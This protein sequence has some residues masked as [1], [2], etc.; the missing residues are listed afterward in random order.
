MAHDFLNTFIPML[1]FLRSAGLPAASRLQSAMGA[2]LSQGRIFGQHHPESAVSIAAAIGD[3]ED[4]VLAMSLA[5]GMISRACAGQLGVAAVGVSC[6]VLRVMS[7]VWEKFR[8]LKFVAA[9]ALHA[10]LKMQLETAI[11]EHA[12]QAPS[13]AMPAEAAAVGIRDMRLR[14]F[15]L[16]PTQ[17]EIILNLAPGQSCPDN[18]GRVP[19]LDWDGSTTRHLAKRGWG[20]Y[21]YEYCL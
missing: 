11:S 9:D 6:P 12:P 1:R 7:P 4:P 21:G 13:C 15:L 10:E 3:A 5:E 16:S 8:A 20:Q 14:D 18:R 2:E 19:V 17:T